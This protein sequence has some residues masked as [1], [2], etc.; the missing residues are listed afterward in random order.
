M[1]QQTVNLINP[2]F[3][4]LFD[5]TMYPHLGLLYLGAVLKKEGF[6]C[7]FIELGDKKE[8]IFPEADHNLITVLCATYKTALDVRNAIK[9]GSIVIGGAQVTCEPEQAFKDFKPDA[10]IKGEGE[11]VIANTLNRISVGERGFIVDGGVVE[12]IN[13]LPYPDRSLLPIEKLRNTQENHVENYRGDGAATTIL[14]SRGCVFNCAF[15][16]KIPQEKK[17]RWRSPQNVMGE[18]DELQ[19]VY[20]IHHARFMDDCFTT[21]RNRVIE[22]CGLLKD[23]EFYWSCL[24]RA[25]AINPKLLTTMYEGGCREIQFGIESGSQR[26]LNLMNK[27][28]AVEKQKSAIKMVHSAGIKSKVFLIE[29]YPTETI[30]DTNLTKQFMIDTQPDKWTISTFMPVPG[31]KIY[32]EYGSDPHYASRTSYNLEKDSAFKTWLKSDVWRL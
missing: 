26:I 10:M 18:I 1:K 11:L 21:N 14:S 19:N 9:S 3:L 2:P 23:K 20:D 30:G 32:K 24:T 13:A 4:E 16:C 27:Q 22:L 15:C 31:S 6:K 5:P 25:D 17:F 8:Y 29:D 28:I 7:R 12:D